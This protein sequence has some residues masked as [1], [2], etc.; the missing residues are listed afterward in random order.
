MMRDLKTIAERA[1]QDR[2]FLT[3]FPEEV[4]QQV[5]REIE[6]PFDAMP[7]RDLSSWCWSS[8]DNDD[9]R[10]LDQIEYAHSEKNG[11]RI[12]VGIADVDYF[13][14]INSPLDRAAAQNTTSVYTGVE[15]FMM[16]PPALST[17]LSSLNEGGKRLAM[18]TELLVN[19][20]GV[21]TESTVYPAIVEN[22]A[23]L[24]YNAV[25]AWLEGTAGTMTN[26]LTEAGRRTLAKIQ[27][28]PELQ[29]QLRL[30]DAAAQRLRV[31][32]HEYG[33]L[34]FDSHELQPVMSAEGEVVDLSTRE[35]H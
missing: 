3:R 27:Q 6:P 1:M 32:R 10:D 23:Q 20:E 9:S 34:S 5:R 12:F 7:I 17:D 13:V 30:Q 26:G 35:H 28:S 11:T 8:I 21:V 33:A 18:V 16:L 31:R 4:H 15:T 2:G 24:T 25:A 22:K 14:P 19:D 29:A